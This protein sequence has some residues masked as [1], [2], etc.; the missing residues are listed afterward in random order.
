MTT[1]TRRTIKT[2]CPMNCHPTYCGMEVEVEGEQVLTIRGDKENP[3][4]R[5]FLCLRGNAA[6][7][8]VDNPLRLFRPL[9]RETRDSSFQATSWDAALDRIAAAIGAV[10]PDEVAV[11]PGHGV[12]VG[13]MG[14]QYANR[15]ANLLGAQAWS[16]SIVCW[17]MGGFGIAAT[18]DFEVNTKEDM[19]ANAD[20]IILW[21][22]NLA[23]QPNTIPHLMAAKRRGAYVVTVDVRRT[24]AADKSD[25]V[26]RLRPSTD[27]AVALAMLHVIIAEERYDPAFVSEHTVGFDALRAHVMQYSPEWAAEISGVPAEQIVAL[28]RRY[29]ETERAM[30]LVGGS[31]MHKSS[32]GW[33]GARAIACLPALCGKLGKPGAGMG[34][35]HAAPT[36][37]QA[38]GN[39]TAREERPPG[40]YQLSQMSEITAA[41]E[42]GKIKVL[43]LLGTDMLS[44]FADAARVQAAL[45]HV[46]LIVSYDLFLNDTA[47]AVADVVLPGT[48]WLEA[49]SLKLTNTHVYLMDQA[50]APRGDARPLNDVLDAL[51]G[52]LGLNDYFPWASS[53]EAI[54]A[55]LN[56]PAVDRVTVDRLRRQHGNQAMSVS[57]VAHPDLRFMTPSGKIEFFSERLAGFGMPALP[58]YEEPSETPRSQIELA[59]RFPLVFRQGRTFAHFHGFYQHGRALPSLRKAEPEPEVWIAPDDAAARGIAPAGPVRVHNDRGSLEARARVTDDIPSG[60]VWMHDGWPGVNRLTSGS[61]VIPDAAVA[62]FPFAAGQAA[63]EALVQVSRVEQDFS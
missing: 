9:V 5:G 34:P 22:A 59:A 37:G 29:A 3:D 32:N 40:D 42:S 24:E 41:I 19:G 16:P 56:H 31:S 48:S 12:F 45:K 51:A 30:I 20:L 50:I 61:T 39:I 58:I 10:R 54:D 13:L 15:F 14:A 23:S 49:P 27:A 36:H 57:H 44:S 35:R 18:G 21:G 4:S 62:G 43:L 28:A 46:D 1:A 52:R 8:I 7:E 26:L 53:E 33:M 6:K 47:A 11:W 60:V 63:Y 38:I 2:M 17:A 55:V 25:E